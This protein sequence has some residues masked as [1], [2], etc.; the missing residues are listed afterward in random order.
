MYDKPFDLDIVAPDRVVFRGSVSSVTVPGALGSFQVLYDHAPLL[1]ELTPGALTI[2]SM[3]GENTYYAVGGGFAEVRANHV[4]ILAD[5]AERADEID[6]ERAEDAKDIAENK[7]H[8]RAPGEN[9]GEAQA[10]FQRAVTRLKV[11]RKRT[12]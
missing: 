9:L 10:A 6:V 8:A 4:V 1:A 12:H 7:L 11:A 5:S 2:R 3:S